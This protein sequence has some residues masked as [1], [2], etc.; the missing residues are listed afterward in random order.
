MKN[1]YIIGMPRCRSLWFAHLLTVN[2]VHCFHERLSKRRIALNPT[3][4]KR[5]HYEC[6]VIGSA[7][8]YPSGFSAELAG[9]APVLVIT[10]PLSDVLM[11]LSKNFDLPATKKAYDYIKS[12][13]E[14]LSLIKTDNMMTV[15]F[16]ELNCVY[17]IKDIADFLGVN[18]SM[19][20]IRRYVNSKITVDNKQVMFSNHAFL[21]MIL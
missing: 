13:H 20:H 2:K 19:R 12:E 5:M 1:F 21:D 18:L 10:R 3:L 16:S 14:V 4:P 9:K 15:G 7:D 8:T 6:D 17:K 11:S